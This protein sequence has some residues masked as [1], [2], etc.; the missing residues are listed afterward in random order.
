MVRGVSMK[1]NSKKFIVILSGIIWFLSYLSLLGRGRVCCGEVSCGEVSYGEVSYGEVSYGEVR[2]S[3]SGQSTSIIVYN[4]L[5]HRTRSGSRNYMGLCGIRAGVLS[6]CHH[7]D[8]VKRR[9]QISRPG[10][11]GPSPAV[12]AAWK[13]RDCKSGLVESYNSP[14]R[15]GGP[16]SKDALRASLLSLCAQVSR[17]KL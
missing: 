10:D 11:G 2:C 8:A 5:T 12:S 16:T 7:S 13:W 3:G 4:R 17:G 9:R 15:Q 1:S 14:N 6:G